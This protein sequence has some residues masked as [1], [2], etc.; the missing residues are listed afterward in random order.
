MKEYWKML[1][2]GLAMLLAVVMVLTSSNLGVVLRAAATGTEDPNAVSITLG[3]LIV[4]NY[5]G[6]TDE[7]KLIISSGQL[8]ADDVYSYVVPTDGSSLIKIEKADELNE[9]VG[10]EVMGKITATTHKDTYK[11]EWYPVSYTIL[12]DNMPVENFVDLPMDNGVAYYTFA[13]SNAFSVEVTYCMDVDL[14]K[15]N[16]AEMLSA[17]ALLAAD[18]EKLVGMKTNI[19]PEKPEG[20][21]ECTTEQER[22][23]RFGQAKVDEIKKHDALLNFVKGAASSVLGGATL[24]LNPL[25]VLTFMTMEL[26]DSENLPISKFFGE[27]MTLVG[28]LGELYKG[29]RYPLEDGMYIELPDGL[30]INA[31]DLFALTYEGDDENGGYVAKLGFTQS[32]ALKQAVE[33]LLMQGVGDDENEPTGLLLKNFLSAHGSKS[34]LEWLVNPT[35][36]A[37]LVA[38]LIGDKNNGNYNDILAMTGG[39]ALVQV[40]TQL[41]DLQYDL[42]VIEDAAWT[43]IKDT[44]GDYG[45]I[46]ENEDD[47]NALLADGFDSL[48]ASYAES[49]GIN[50]Q[51]ADLNAQIAKYSEYGVKTFKK[52]A[53]ESKQDLVDFIDYLKSTKGTLS[54]AVETI[55]GRWDSALREAGYTGE[56][57]RTVDEA[58]AA[59]AQMEADAEAEQDK[60]DAAKKAVAELL[61]EYP[62]A[63]AVNKVEDIAAAITYLYSLQS[64]D[65]LDAA[66]KALND[67]KAAAKKLAE[68]TYGLKNVVI[69]SSADIDAIV[70]ANGPLDKQVE[71]ALAA[72]NSRLDEVN[73][74]LGTYLAN[75]PEGVTPPYETIENAEQFEHF[76]DWMETE[77]A[78][79]KNDFKATL[80][81]I[82]TAVKEANDKLPAGFE[83]CNV[84]LSPDDDDAD[85]LK[86]KIGAIRT[87]MNDLVA[88]ATEMKKDALADANATLTSYDELAD[89]VEKN[90]EIKTVADIEKLSAYV[91]EKFAALTADIYQ[92]INTPENMDDVRVVYGYTGGDVASVQDVRDIV[93]FMENEAED[94]LWAQ[95]NTEIDGVNAKIDMVNAVRPGSFE[96]LP[97]VNNVDGA[98]DVKNQMIAYGYEEY[99][100]VLDTCIDAAKSIPTVVNYL[101]D[102]IDKLEELEKTKTDIK[103]TLS[104]ASKDF[105]DAEANFAEMNS[106]VAEYGELLDDAEEQLPEAKTFIE[107]AEKLINNGTLAEK[108]IELYDLM[109]AYLRLKNDLAN[110]KAA[111]NAEKEK[112]VAAEEA[113]EDARKELGDDVKELVAGLEAQRSAWAAAE[114]K[115]AE[116]EAIADAMEDE[117]NLKLLTTA[118]EVAGYQDDIDKYLEELP[119]QLKEAEDAWATLETIPG[120]LKTL[121]DTRNELKSVKD[122]LDIM[123]ILLELL[124]DALEPAATACGTKDGWNAPNKLIDYN[125]TA[126]YAELT[127]AATG[128]KAN[129]IDLI[130]TIVKYAS[131]KLTANMSMFDVQVVIKAQV[132][133]DQNELVE[134]KSFDAGKKTLVAGDAGVLGV[135][136]ELLEKNQAAAWNSFAEQYKLF[137]TDC[138]TIKL[139]VKNDKGELIDKV[140]DALDQNLTI[141]FVYTPN[142]VE[143]TS[144]IEELAGKYAYGWNLILPEHENA[145]KEWEYSVKFGGSTKGYRQGET[146]VL[147]GLTEISRKVGDKSASELVEDVVIKTVGDLNDI[148]DAILKS[149]ALKLNDSIYIRVPNNNHLVKSTAGN[150]TTVTA[151]PYN[152]G[153]YGDWIPVSA[154]IDGEIVEIKD[155]GIIETEA[156]FEKIVVNYALELSS[157]EL[158]VDLGEYINAPYQLAADYNTQ[159]SVLD[160]LVAAV[161]VD[162]NSD[163]KAETLEALGM[164]DR[165]TE[166][167]G[168]RLGDVFGMLGGTMEESIKK[169]IMDQL[170][171]DDATANQLLVAL[172]AM[173]NEDIL[174]TSGKTPLYGTLE[175]YTKQGMA[176]YYKYSDNYIEQIAQLNE[177]MQLMPVEALSGLGGVGKA[178]KA[179]YDALGSAEADLQNYPVSKLIKVDSDSLNTLLDNLGKYKQAE[180]Y[181]VPAALTWKV[182]LTATGDGI[183]LHMVTVNVEG[184]GT[185]TSE[186]ITVKPGQP[187]DHATEAGNIFND[188]V[189]ESIRK[190]FKD[191]VVTTEVTEDGT[192]NHIYTINRNS[193]DVVIPGVGTVTLTYLNPVITLVRHETAGFAWMYDVPGEPAPVEVRHSASE[194]REYPLTLDQLDALIAG[195]EITRTEVNVGEADLIDTIEKMGGVLFKDADGKYSMVVGIDLN[196]TESLMNFVLNLYTN[197]DVQLGGETL[198]A[199]SQFHLQTLIDVLLNSGISTSDLNANIAANGTVKNTLVLPEGLTAI[200]NK[201][202]SGNHMTLIEST[203]TMKGLETMPLYLTLTGDAS[204]VK[205]ALNTISGY[206]VDVQLDNGSANLTIT[207]PEPFYTAYLATLSMVGEV[208][209]RNVNDVNAEIA[210]GYI[211]NMITEIMNT[212]GVSIETFGNTIGKDLSGYESYYDMAKDLMNM[213]TFVDDCTITLDLPVIPIKGVIDSLEDSI[214]LPIEGVSLGGMIAEY[215]T[216]LDVAVGAK[217][218]NFANDYDVLFVDVKAGG[219]A[220][221]V[222]MKALD[223]TGKLDLATTSVV[224]LLNDIENLYITD[225]MTL[226][227]LNGFNVTG[228]ITGGPSADVIVVDSNYVA[229]EGVVGNVSGNVTLLAGKYLNDVSAYVNDGYMQD[230][231][232]VVCNK[233]FTVSETDNVITVTL[234]TTVA[235]AKTLL[236]QEGVFGLAAEILFDQFINHYNVAG[237]SMDGNMIYNI[238]FEDILGIVSGG[239]DAIVDTA[240]AFVDEAQLSAV[241]NALI[242]DLTDY[243][244]IG[245]ALSD[246]GNGVIASHNFTTTTWGLDLTH[247][248]ENDT[249]DVNF[250][251]SYGKSETKTLQLEIEGE[252][253]GAMATLA[254]ALGKVLTVKVELG[255]EDIYRNDAGQFNVKGEFTGSVVFDFTSGDYGVMMAL[256]MANG[257]DED[258]KA[259]LVEAVETYYATTD[260]AMLR[261]VYNALTI[262]DICSSLANGHN[263][264]TTISEIVENLGLTCADKVLANVDES[265][266]GFDLLIDALAYGL[267]LLDSYG[268]G[269]TVTDSGFKLGR[270]ETSDDKGYYYGRSGSKGISGSNTYLDYALNAET[271]ELKV[272]LFGEHVCKFDQKRVAPEY[273]MAEATYDEAAKYY[274]SCICGKSSEGITNEWFH[275]GDILV[276]AP[277]IEIDADKIKIDGDKLY[278]VKYDE[279]KG[280]LILDTIADGMT[281]AEVLAIL[282]Q[283][284]EVENDMDDK[285]EKVT[286]N[287][288]GSNGLVGT[289]STFTL[290]AKNSVGD[291]DEVTVTIIILGDT[292]CNGRLE[293]GDAVVMS[294]FVLGEEQQALTPIQIVAANANGLT[295]SFGRE[296]VDSGDAVIVMNKWQDNYGDNLPEYV[297]PLN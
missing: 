278:G 84:V 164:L 239:T 113:L 234:N 36:R 77:L 176:H 128:L 45:M 193:Y 290:Q 20:W 138:F 104:Q 235:D 248:S 38:A 174:P 153:A 72:Y 179:L 277:T 32:R 297:S 291:T 124:C 253:R 168:F 286:S 267:R 89:Y 31:D 116:Y 64:S 4:E 282:T 156:A 204:A 173:D 101:N 154:T 47:L 12:V 115:K 131:T 66:N 49:K 147:R 205:G 139:V 284:S 140:P 33:R 122:M 159:K 51:L 257:A 112:I 69:N 157:S 296:G 102:V 223:E 71:D 119:A 136:T 165:N 152:S 208:D 83:K 281:E 295:S 222:G 194:D 272:Y 190:Y 268:F 58:K 5:D 185:K 226:V 43:M 22:I 65:E 150:M 127:E 229:D 34:Y 265:E 228:T 247:D 238:N 260:P 141:E 81:D 292:N 123:I 177:V 180:P 167:M 250:G 62:A 90:G 52:D 25:M 213:V 97:H 9:V 8:N 233:L 121:D 137:N 256:I 92:A 144:D 17:G 13:G 181:T 78:K 251:G 130:E 80:D 82:N 255:L 99:T 211:T 198:V 182:D 206:G 30:E 293:S 214:E 148:A 259:D 219:L 3:E 68:E 135:A 27:G 98:R 151:L 200:G 132:V 100:G 192:V 57:I 252:A 59:I 114:Q 39:D 243:A 61:K 2:R 232:G 218:N 23:D 10:D 225:T 118:K 16:Q 129:N 14:T 67:A 134:L 6:L 53:I 275:H 70:A 95:V 263:S 209:L 195:A 196:N 149:D 11:N 160:N 86:S 240:L 46:I 155:G 241:F 145:E 50:D 162:T 175:N 54:A 236:T 191:A 109:N 87:W 106:L 170:G 110:K 210:L 37:E 29:I 41:E 276:K 261:E 274:Y 76:C 280:Y 245:A 63:P 188:M 108:E 1:K 197:G 91:N 202:L 21:E 287:V 201:T 161:T 221:K 126:N 186:V 279:A 242:A 269:E 171:V 125:K 44:A 28:L 258:L 199:N 35:I 227:D 142:E 249:L 266:M 285:A 75:L 60:I 262:E 19:V 163:N 246:D 143:V 120:A 264:T 230:G 294:M 237:V 24:E 93:T 216:G 56:E 103:N 271:I 288:V 254:T 207:I 146:V 96:R 18:I 133:N 111:M 88:T 217:I 224:I 40:S 117:T 289:G 158:G 187:F 74:L 55:Y 79:A 7:E 178:F 231:R 183:E 105:E 270:L 85:T 189:E 220:N 107:D 215:E 42:D 212:E 184:F 166:M 244:N 26:P 283:G 15:Y 203:L 94:N 73:N 169:I 48:L 273:L 172:K